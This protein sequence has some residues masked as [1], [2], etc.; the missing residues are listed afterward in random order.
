MEMFRLNYRDGEEA[1]AWRWIKF[2]IRDFGEL[3]SLSQHHG[4]IGARPAV[5][6]AREHDPHHFKEFYVKP[7]GYFV[8]RGEYIKEGV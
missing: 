7:I 1:R 6:T 5:R 2:P 8:I 3:L 4:Q